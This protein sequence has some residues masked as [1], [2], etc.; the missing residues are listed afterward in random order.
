MEESEANNL[1]LGCY[2]DGKE[3]P[4]L[5]FFDAKEKKAEA[6]LTEINPSYVIKSNDHYYV[7][8]EHP[9]GLIVT[10]NSKF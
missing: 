3:A 2:S 8:T 9:T 1:V 7:A 10:L 5:F 4:S 6:I